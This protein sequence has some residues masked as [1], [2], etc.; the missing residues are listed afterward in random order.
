V[1][2]RTTSELRALGAR[3]LPGVSAVVNG[4]TDAAT[5]GLGDPYVAL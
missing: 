1:A 3:V 4:A 5:A 2:A